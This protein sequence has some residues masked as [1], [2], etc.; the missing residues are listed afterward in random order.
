MLAQE[1]G[2][3]AGNPGLEGLLLL[4]GPAGHLVDLPPV[5][6]LPY[7]DP[8]P[9]RHVHGLRAL[10]LAQP[11]LQISQLLLQPLVLGGQVH[12]RVAPGPLD[13]GHGHLDRKLWRGCKR[14]RHDVLHALALLPDPRKAVLVVRQVERPRRGARVGRGDLVAVAV[15]VPVPVRPLGQWGVLFALA[16]HTAAPTPLLLLLLLRLPQGDLSL[17]VHDTLGQPLHVGLSLL[18]LEDR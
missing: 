13:L 2:P 11:P 4:G 18:L 17:Q 14:R 8:R 6:T 15:P 16:V 7:V 5:S 10:P 9:A 1:C 12:E 3:V